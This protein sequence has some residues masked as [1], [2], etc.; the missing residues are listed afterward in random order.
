[1]GTPK[2]LPLRCVLAFVGLLV[3]L[4]AAL[5]QDAPAPPPAATDA[6][7]AAPAA[8][9]PAGG[10]T[11]LAGTRPKVLVLPAE[12]TVYQL[13]VAGPEVVPEWTTAARTNVHEG[14]GIV[15]ANHAGLDYTAIPDMTA[16]E[17]QVLDDYIAV[18]KVVTMQGQI[19]KA[20]PW[21]TR[22]PEFDRHLGDGLAF[23]RER[24]GADYA[25]LVHGTQVEQSGG[26]IATQLLAAAAGVVMVMGG[27]T[28]L[29]ATV[30]DLNTGDVKWF[31]TA[32]GAEILGI[33]SLDMRKPESTAKVLEKLFE[34]YPS[35]PALDPK[36]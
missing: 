23:L 33:G 24:T 30:L 29:S 18:A 19:L 12:V 27:G 22:R 9:P 5:G 15:M 10:D 16:A 4:P 25:V 21:A 35:I 11:K 20:R 34:P 6:T 26:A 28:H 7:P 8:V 1:M 17:K 36:K 31:N 14:L 3:V 13:G 2:T 32:D